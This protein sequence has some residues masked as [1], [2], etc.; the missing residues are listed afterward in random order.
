MAKHY[1]VDDR[2]CAAVDARDEAV[3]LAGHRAPEHGAFGEQIARH[4]GLAFAPEVDWTS[5]FRCN[6]KSST[7]KLVDPIIHQPAAGTEQVD[8]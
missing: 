7:R 6:E 4:A 8:E 5:Q 3:V 1:Q 2:L